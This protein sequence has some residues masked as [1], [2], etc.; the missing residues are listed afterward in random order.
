MTNIKCDSCKEKFE[1]KRINT[2]HLGNGIEKSSF[3]CPHCTAEYVTCYTDKQIRKLQL[4]IKRLR[5]KSKKF[6]GEGREEI[7]QQIEDM[8]ERCKTLI[9]ELTISV[10]GSQV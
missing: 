3:S 7:V 10:T 2:F 6:R 5:A 4:E 8:S 9:R 1:I